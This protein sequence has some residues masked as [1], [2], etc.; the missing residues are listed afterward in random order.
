M[1]PTEMTP[2]GRYYVD[3]LPYWPYC[4]KGLGALYKRPRDHY[5]KYTHIEHNEP[6]LVRWLV[7][8]IDYN[9]NLGSFVWDRKD[10]PVPNIVVRN[11]DNGHAHFFYKL[12]DPVGRSSTSHQGPMRY[13]AHIENGLCEY[14]KADRGYTGLISKN[15]FH[16]EWLTHFIHNHGYTLGELDD[17]VPETCYIRSKSYSETYGLGRNCSVFELLKQWAYK[18]FRLD[19]NYSTKGW[20]EA[21]LKQAS[22]FNRDVCL[23]SPLPHNELKAIAKS[24]A[25]WVSAHFKPREF[26]VIQA[27]RG[28]RKGKEMRD[29]YLQRVLDLDAK[30]VKPKDIAFALPEI[31]V[32]VINS[33][34]RRYRD[35][36]G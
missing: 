13:L 22:D 36:T 2:V 18:A 24:V 32:S 35:T 1:K 14:L 23:E 4:A 10:I 26:K 17:Y 12:K 8:D 11:P 34:L 3:N 20:D 30:G 25:K 15:P 28:K 16:H 9:V 29:L 5:K 7:F 31:N 27:S 6:T 33:W 19:F 21:C